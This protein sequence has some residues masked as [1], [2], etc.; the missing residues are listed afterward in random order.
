[1]F[2][3]PSQ[4]VP[5]RRLFATALGLG[6][7][8]VGATMAQTPNA[9]DLGADV[10]AVDQLVVT[11]S[12]FARKIV[13]APASISVISREV[14]GVDVG[15]AYAIHQEPRRLWVSVNVDF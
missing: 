2:I 6:L 7:C 15:G 11:A 4:G 8:V 9:T 1:M 5:R 10:V 14:E 3:S 13:D 12:T